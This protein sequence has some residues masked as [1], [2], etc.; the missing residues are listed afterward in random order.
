MFHDARPVAG[1]R[2]AGYQ[3]ILTMVSVI[4]PYYNPQSD[5]EID[6]LLERAVCSAVHELDGHTGFE[7]IVVNDGSPCRPVIQAACSDSRIRFIDREHGK[8]GAARNTG[9]DS[10]KG[11]ILT[12]LDA[13]DFY[14]EDTLWPCVMAME[15][16]GAD[17]LGYGFSNSYSRTG[18]ERLRQPVPSFSEPVP[19][20]EWMRSNNLFGSSCMFLI[21]RKLIMDNSLRFMEN[22]FIE[23]EEFTPR[24]VFSS[25]RFVHTSFKVYGYYRRNCSIIT[26]MTEAAVREREVNTLIAI[27]RLVEYRNG[28]L[29]ESTDGLDRKIGTLAIDCIRRALQSREWR[30]RAAAAIAGLKDIGLY[31]VPTSSLPFGLRLYAGLAKCSPG[32][33]LLHLL[34]TTGK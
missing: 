20:N 21:D 4:I 15:S 24:L 30:K 8:L 18:T 5:A 16:S 25:R 2:S 31:P 17:L 13:D 10:S 1:K 3:E 26:T 9:I 27:T 29:H 23:D 22:L 28:V 33:S 14:L 19:G 6:R 11:G 7:V 12:F 34:E 32:R